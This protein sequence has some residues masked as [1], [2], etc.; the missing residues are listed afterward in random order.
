M[1]HILAWPYGNKN[2]DILPGKQMFLKQNM[3]LGKKK[4]YKKIILY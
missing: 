4:N 3:N 2:L 1:G